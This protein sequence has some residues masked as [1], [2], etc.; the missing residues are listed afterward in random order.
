MRDYGISE[1]LVK[2]LNRLYEDTKAQVRVNGV[3]SDAL[4]L[5]TRVKQGCVLSPLL[6]NIFMDW[7]FRE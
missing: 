2:I 6:F 4:S 1:K 5:K 3:L 7:Q